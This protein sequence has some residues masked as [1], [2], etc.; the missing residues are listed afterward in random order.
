MGCKRRT[1]LFAFHLNSEVLANP[2]VGTYFRTPR[3]TFHPCSGQRGGARPLTVSP[4]DKPRIHDLGRGLFIS[5]VK[6][7]QVHLVPSQP[8]VSVYTD[9][10]GHRVAYLDGIGPRISEFCLVLRQFNRGGLNWAFHCSAHSLQRVQE[11][12]FDGPLMQRDLEC[13]R[14]F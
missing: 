5:G 3:S 11:D 14:E 1:C 8:S 6:P 9:A 10:S 4:N 2:R 12:R 7:F 13:S